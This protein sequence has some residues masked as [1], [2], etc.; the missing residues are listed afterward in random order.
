MASLYVGVYM[1]KI[2]YLF[3]T[4]KPILNKVSK[5]VDDDTVTKEKVFY[6]VAIIIILLFLTACNKNID[7]KTTILK[8]IVKEKIKE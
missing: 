8:Q 3:K 1:N 2:I 7:P 6:A 4:M 5:Y